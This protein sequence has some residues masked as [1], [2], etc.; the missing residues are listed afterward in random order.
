MP[1]SKP[2]PKVNFARPNTLAVELRRRINDK[3]RRENLLMRAYI[4]LWAKGLLMIA[5]LVVSVGGL[6]FGPHTWWTIILLMISAALALVGVAF[7][8]GHDFIHGAGFPKKL[9][10]HS[11]TARVFNKLGKMSFDAI[12]AS[13][14]IWYVKHVVAHHTW[15]NITGHDSDI[16]QAPAIRLDPA[17]EYRPWY[18]SQH[19][20]GWLMYGLIVPKWHFIGD[21]SNLRSGKIAETEI[22]KMTLADRLTFWGGKLFFFSWALGLPLWLHHDS[23]GKIAAVVAIYFGTAMMAGTVLALVFQLAHAIEGAKFVKPD[24]DGDGANAWGI[25]QLETTRDFYYS[26]RLLN[27]PINGLMSF[28]L[29]GLNFQAIHHILPMLPHPLY[30]KVWREFAQ[31]CADHDVEYVRI[32]LGRAIVLHGR[33]LYMMGRPSGHVTELPIA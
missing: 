18:R 15:T 28:Y 29:G 5:W 25:H 11:R 23:P 6:I 4:A 26:G 14:F 20:Y 31:F 3:I 19:I 8:I 7:N 12:G 13:S 27:K 24:D 17:Q 16:D 33:W 32:P 30:H 1:A 21:F 22:P 10:D 9:T 2:K